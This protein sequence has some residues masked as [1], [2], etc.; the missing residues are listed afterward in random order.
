M[1]NLGWIRRCDIWRKLLALARHTRV[2][3]AVHDSFV[4]HVVQP[5]GMCCGEIRFVR[6]AAKRKK[7]GQSLCE[8]IRDASTAKPRPFW[9]K[10]RYMISFVCFQLSKKWR[11]RARQRVRCSGRSAFRARIFSSEPA[12]SAISCELRFDIL[13]RITFNLL[14]STDLSL[15]LFLS[16]IKVYI[17]FF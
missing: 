11:F 5:L 17:K 14:T 16:I 2:Y 13:T 7:W 3:G 9:V 8:A 4:F 12:F 10:L 15:M 1:M 6:D